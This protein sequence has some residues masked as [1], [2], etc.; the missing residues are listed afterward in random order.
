V[1]NSVY[2]THFRAH[3]DTNT[4]KTDMLYFGTC[5]LSDSSMNKL[6]YFVRF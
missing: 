1:V 2:I 3:D 4:F 5:I 6:N